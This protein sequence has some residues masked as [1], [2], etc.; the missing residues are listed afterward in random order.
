MSDD[1]IKVLENELTA[2]LDSLDEVRD[3]LKHGHLDWLVVV[4]QAGRE[5]QTRHWCEDLDGVLACT[6]RGAL[7]NAAD[8]VVQIAVDE[9]E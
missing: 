8:H 3:M 1:K 7:E 4:Y 5:V 6:I 2:S 9:E